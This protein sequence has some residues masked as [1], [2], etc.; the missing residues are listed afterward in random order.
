MPR[1]KPYVPKPFESTGLSSDTSANIYMSML[2]SYA[3][4]K[5]TKNQQ[6]LYLYC[7]AQYYA[8]KDKDK[9]KPKIAQ[10]SAE[11]F[12]R[13]FTMNK[14]KWCNLYHLYNNGNQGS[15]AKDMRALVK[16]GFV[17]LVEEGKNISSCNIYMLSDKWWTNTN[18]EQGT[19]KKNIR[20][21]TVYLH[22]FPNNKKYYG[23]T[24]QKP[25][26]RWLKG[27]GYVK[28]KKMYNEILKVGWDNIQHLEILK[29][30]DV[31]EAVIYEYAYI[32]KDKTY[33]EEN[34]FNHEKIDIDYFKQNLF[35]SDE[36]IYRERLL[37]LDKILKEVLK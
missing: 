21:Y 28:N 3:W 16:W 37:K 24:G 20:I 31:I 35:V 36:K 4:Q 11:E 5:L 13:C 29:T 26:Q 33:L 10:L 7:K 14:S 15:F 34:G 19:I 12:R 32:L 22:I 30:E 18:K 6:V 17:E 2:T 27:R 9:Q 25:K 23:F 1:K 8:Q